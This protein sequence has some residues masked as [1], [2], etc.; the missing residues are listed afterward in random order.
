MNSRKA[1]G[2][3]QN[4]FLIEIVPS[5]KEFEKEF[6][7]MGST[8]NV[9]HVTIREYPTCTCPDFMTRMRRC[10][11]IFFILIKVM[12]IKNSDQE[13]YYDDEL[14]E[15]FKNIPQITENLVA[16]SVIKE[17]YKRINSIDEKEEENEKDEKVKKK[18]IDDI[19]PICLEN[20]D[21]GQDV[22]YCKYSCGKQIHKLCFKMWCKKNQPTCV[23]CRGEWTEREKKE[24]FSFME[25]VNLLGKNN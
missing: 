15:M 23:F 6:I 8:G 12:K 5:D 20:L 7:V 22:D 10:K 19:C 1:K 2:I 24:N 3:T 18:S 13:E 21:N 4:L 14:L 16:D 17:K 11:H 25:Y 9:Y